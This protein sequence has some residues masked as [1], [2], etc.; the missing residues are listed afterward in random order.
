MLDMNDL[1]DDEPFQQQTMNDNYMQFNGNYYHYCCST[2]DDVDTVLSYAMIC[3]TYFITFV[4]MHGI[5]YI[6]L[7]LLYH[8]HH[9]QTECTPL[10]V[11]VVV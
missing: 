10:R 5:Q 2:D 11:I 3:H 9:F 6:I 7:S 4:Y 1:T 8:Y